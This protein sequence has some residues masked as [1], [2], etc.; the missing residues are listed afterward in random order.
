MANS[1]ICKIRVNYA[2]LDMGFLAI[3]VNE[4]GTV[5]KYCLTYRNFEWYFFVFLLILMW[6]AGGAIE[7]EEEGEMV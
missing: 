4:C 1:D 3:S 6:R 2:K 7:D 5:G